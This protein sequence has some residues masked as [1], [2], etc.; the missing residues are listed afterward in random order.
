M[1][2]ET[3]LSLGDRRSVAIVAVEGRRFLVGLTP[4]QI[5]LVTELG[6]APA[7]FDQT[8]SRAAAAS[9]GERS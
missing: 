8:L 7:S 3:A 1:R 6:P 5:S 9:S 4:A 2:V